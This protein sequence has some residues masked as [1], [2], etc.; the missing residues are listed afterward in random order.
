MLNDDTTDPV[1]GL[2]MDT[3]HALTFKGENMLLHDFVNMTAGKQ[4]NVWVANLDHKA[5]Y[6][7]TNRRANF[8]VAK[9]G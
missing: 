8:V 4:H 5:Q 6:M 9:M 2:D 3:F 1:Y 7:C